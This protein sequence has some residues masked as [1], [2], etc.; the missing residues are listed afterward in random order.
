MTDVTSLKSNR[1]QMESEGKLPD[2]IHYNK[3]AVTGLLLLGA[4]VNHSMDDAVDKAI[5]AE[6]NNEEI[7]PVNAPKLPDFTKDMHESEADKKSNSSEQPKSTQTQRTSASKHK[8]KILPETES[9]STDTPKSPSA[10]LIITKHRLKKTP[11]TTTTTQK[12]H[13]TVCR[14]A[15]DDKDTLKE[16]H[17]TTHTNSQC[18]VCNKSFA[19]KRSLRKHSYTHLETQIKC[20]CHRVFACF[21]DQEMITQNLLTL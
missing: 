18:D 11:V 19:T 16:H 13:C 8:H 3:D 20:K 10:R 5:D 4:S 2:L 17:H 12:V 6:I 9:S 21:L 1:D 14:K 7:L 15:F